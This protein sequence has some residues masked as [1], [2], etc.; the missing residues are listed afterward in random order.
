[1]RPQLAVS[2]SSHLRVVYLNIRASG[3]RGHE[4]RMNLMSTMQ[5]GPDT[6]NGN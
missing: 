3:I 5:P 6:L 2:P 1:L 4:Q